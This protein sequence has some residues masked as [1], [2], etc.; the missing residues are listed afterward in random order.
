MGIAS[1]VSGAMGSLG[2]RILGAMAIALVTSQPEAQTLSPDL[3][4]YAAIENWCGRGEIPLNPTT[5]PWIGCFHLSAGRDVA[6]EFLNHH[7]V[8]KI[9]DD[10]KRVLAVDGTVIYSDN[11][12]AQE[13]I[14]PFMI[15]NSDGYGICEGTSTTKCHSYI[16]PFKKLPDKSIIFVTT[17]CLPPGYWVCVTT[18]ANWD[19]EEKT[20]PPGLR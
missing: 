16:G 1:I 6:G 17:E 4:P 19:Y 5:I 7:V 9:G 3:A 8:I 12:P 2:I 15:S 10:G 14:L 11:T 13:H 20:R 18:Q